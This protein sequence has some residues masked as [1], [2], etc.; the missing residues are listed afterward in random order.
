MLDDLNVHGGRDDAMYHRTRQTPPK[1][2]PLTDREVPIGLDR[3]PA[4]IQE[5]LDGDAS[6]T[7]VRQ[8]ETVRH[9]EFWNRI[10]AEV[11]E[12]RRM[13]TPA[14]VQ[15]A[16]MD[17]LPR[18]APRAPEV[19][20]QRRVVVTPATMIVGAASLLAVGVVLGAALRN[21]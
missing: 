14:H 1:S 12:R 21:P 4:T 10:N 20:W 2:Q 8:G 16:I 7:A 5:W 11:E 9:V 6:E 3:T 18:T 19:W 15:K 13:R 17:A